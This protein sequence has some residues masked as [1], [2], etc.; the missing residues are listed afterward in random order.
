MEQNKFTKIRLRGYFM[1][2][3]LP[4]TTYTVYQPNGIPTVRGYY[5]DGRWMYEI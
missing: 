2:D 1:Q 5:K 4:G 3:Q